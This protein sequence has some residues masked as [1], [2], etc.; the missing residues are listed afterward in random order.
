MDVIF[1]EEVMYKD[2]LGTEADR[3]YLEVKKMEIIQSNYI[4]ID[5]QEDQEVVA[6]AVD[7][8]TP[9]LELRRSF[10]TI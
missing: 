3:A 9:I 4:L 7:P 5:S 2:R 1:N 8:Q 6:L 10:K